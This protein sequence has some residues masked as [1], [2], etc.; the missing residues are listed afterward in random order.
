[1]N[2]NRAQHQERMSVRWL[3]ALLAADAI[4]TESVEPL[5]PVCCCGPDFTG[6]DGYGYRSINAGCRIHGLGTGVGE[7]RREIL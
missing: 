2:T 7:R 3:E 4:H 6:S 5:P 1:M